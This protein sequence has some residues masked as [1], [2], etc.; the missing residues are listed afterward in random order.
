MAEFTRSV[1][2]TRPREQGAEFASLLASE[3]IRPLF[4][5]AIEILPPE[6]WTAL[7]DALARMESFD[8]IIFTSA[9][10][11]AA[12]FDRREAA[13]F[14]GGEGGALPP[15][16][17]VG[18]KTRRAAEARG[19]R[20]TAVPETYDG[21]HLA[22][23][24]GGAAGRR[25]LLPQSDI[26]REEIAALLE[27]AGASVERVTAYR[28]A[29]PSGAERSR[30]ENMLVEGEVDCIAF[31]SPSAARN[32]AALIPAF[33]QA[34]ILVAAIGG[35]TAAAAL[36]SGFRV[37]LIAPEA[38][39]ESLARAIIARL[40]SDDRIELDHRLISDDL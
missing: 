17:A 20:C 18:E 7:D 10:A 2:I 37:D 13:G 29:A 16:C 6:S 33:K 23:A 34:T 1:L 4:F 28:T 11:V 31:F 30:L 32:F 22:E 12:F 5:P 40:R 39:G 21:R 9:N 15:C 24:I 35:T 19:A 25:F 3:G 38:T 26:G 14:A 27:Q 8:G 36:A